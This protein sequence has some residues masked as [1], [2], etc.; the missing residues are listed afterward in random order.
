[1]RRIFVA[2]GWIAAVLAT[3]AAAQSVSP[4]SLRAAARTGRTHFFEQYYQAGL[5]RLASGDAARALP[6]FETASDV[7]PDLPQLH[8]QV[9]LAQVLA[10]FRE[11]QLAL[12]AIR[13][14]MAGDPANPVYRILAALADPA[15]STPG[16]DGGL[17]FTPE[18]AALVAA[19]MPKIADLRDAA[20]A[21][22]FVP[23]LATIE[24]TGIVVLPKRLPGFATTL[25]TRQPVT[26][27]RVAEPQTVG[28]LLMVAVGDAALRP[29]EEAF[30]DRL[31]DGRVAESSVIGIDL[32]AR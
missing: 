22:Y 2:A 13:R 23:V 26:L 4:D 16:A 19:A 24:P 20:N 8:Y 18:G 25:G 6:L 10:D 11:R 31:L 7:A 3:A 5:A 15:L 32:A 28:R 17:Y 14:A 30:V 1:M 9:A 21:R 12:P 29:Y 27:P